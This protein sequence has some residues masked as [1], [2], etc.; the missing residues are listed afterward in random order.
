MRIFLGRD[1]SWLVHIQQIAVHVVLH[2]EARRVKPVVEDLATHDMSS[3]APAVFVALL[4]QPVVTKDL[5]V[6]VMGLVR[7]VVDVELGA[8]EE[9]KDVMV[10]QLLS[11]VQPEEGRVVLTRVVVN[12]LSMS[13]QTTYRTRS[14]WAV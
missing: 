5:R 13:G 11:A 8:L 2:D 4:A 12:Q 6:K 7:C 9:E 10:Y 1:V 14:A 3:H